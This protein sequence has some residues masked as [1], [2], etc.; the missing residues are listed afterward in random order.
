MAGR[1]GRAG[2][3]GARAGGVARDRPAQ[4]RPPRRARA[5]AAGGTDPRRRD[6]AGGARGLAAGGAPPGHAR[7]RAQRARRQAGGRAL[8][9]AAVRRRRAGRVSL[10]VRRAG[11][12]VADAGCRRPA[13]GRRLQ[14][15][16]GGGRRGAHREDRRLAP[17][18]PAP[19]QRPSAP[20]RARSAK[21]RRRRSVLAGPPCGA[22]RHH[23]ARAQGGDRAHD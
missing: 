15:R 4:R 3:L 6:A 20:H 5:R 19:P 21:P 17:A 12:R 11:L 16:L 23:A 18:D 13:V 1:P 7:H 9:A 2:A 10:H 8:C 22:R 14:G